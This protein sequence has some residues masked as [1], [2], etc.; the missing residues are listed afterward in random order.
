MN[1]VIIIAEAG[2][3][4][5]GDMELAKK[6]IDEAK[7][8]G[9][10]Y[11]KFQ[12][13]KTS[14]LTTKE[15]KQAKYQVQNTKIEES[16]H[17]MLTRLELS[18]DQFIELKSH[19]EKMGIGFLSSAFDLDSVDTLASI[20][21]DYWKIPS[22][23]ITNLPY[24]RKIASLKK[25][26]I[27][28]TGMAFLNEVESA[29]KVFRD[30]GIDQKQITVLQCTSNYPSE[31]HEINLNAM[32][33]MGEVLNCPIGLSDHSPGVEA[34]IAAVALG[35]TLIEKHFTLD[36]ELEGPDHKASLNPIELKTLV[37]S[38]RNI[39]K[40]MGSSIKEP[41]KSE[42]DNREVSRKSLVAA[43]DIKKGETLDES[44]LTTKRPGHGINPMRWNEFLGI[45]S[46]RD[47]VQDELIKES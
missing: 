17:E 18:Q 12:T 26:I 46:Q 42:L 27:L 47:Y 8:C 44:N 13:F 23:E 36:K 10:D 7:S 45:E 33:K 21:M 22:G 39:E 5:N 6:L 30:E 41:Y 2:V 3:N 32:N 43:R 24:L 35:A 31:F 38:I 25:P 9:A 1:N 11:V 20:G 16:Q 34:S 28:S 19:C 4:H 29:F 37:S 40:A 14:S 15:T